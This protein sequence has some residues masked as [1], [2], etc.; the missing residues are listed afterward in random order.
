[1]DE[2]DAEMIPTLESPLEFQICTG[3]NKVVQLS[4]QIISSAE[5][6]ESDEKGKLSQR[7]EQST[8]S[9]SPRARV[10]NIQESLLLS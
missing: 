7:A 5:T 10:I 3:K 6:K 9:E 1:M 4:L 8:K 2:K